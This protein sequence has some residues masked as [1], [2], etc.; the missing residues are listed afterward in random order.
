MCGVTKSIIRVAERECRILRKNRVY[1]SF[2][3]V[4]PIIVMFFFTSLMGDGQPT[5]MPVGLVDNDNTTTTR[6][7]AR[8]LDAFQ[9][10]KITNKYA[11]VS[12]ARNGIQ[13]NEI[14]AFLYIPKGTTEKLMSMRQPKI[15]FYYSSTSLTAGSLLYKDLKTISTLGSAAAASSTLSAKGLTGRQISEFLQPIAIDTH[16]INNPAAN[17]SVYLNNMIIPGCIMLFIFLLT[18]Y[19]IG[20]EVKFNTAKEWLATADGSILSAITGKL[21][22]QTLVFLLIVYAY[23]FYVFAFLEFPHAGG[24]PYMLMLGLLTVVSAQGLG[25]FAYGL[26]PSLRMSMS[27]CSLWAV[28]SFSLAG[29]AFPVSAMDSE[30]KTISSLFPLR[31]YYMVYQLNIFNGYPLSF[32]WLH[33]VALALFAILPL[34][35]IGRLKK[36]VIENSYMP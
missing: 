18:A 34:L 35:V 19:S 32:S 7:L 8:K 11:S 25:V 28:L 5:D 30:L 36:A 23:M 33:C 4:V 3:V 20:T 15:S 14:Y 26:A 1:F 9:S 17:Y 27:I 12:E 24:V 21:L 13:R 29:T 10:S 2:M 16:L 22:P 6:A 31:H